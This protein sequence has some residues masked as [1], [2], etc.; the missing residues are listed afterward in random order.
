MHFIS[1]LT[2]ENI[3]KSVSTTTSTVIGTALLTAA[4]ALP[5]VEFAYGDA[6]PERG[7]VSFKYL[8]YQD[9][10]GIVTQSGSN[11]NGVNTVSGASSVAAS[12]SSSSG[13]QN[14]IGVVLDLHDPHPEHGRMD[15][16]SHRRSGAL[17]LC[18]RPCPSGGSNTG[19]RG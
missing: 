14:R 11:A 13:Y 9:S 2:P 17:G 3:M 18:S 6:V 8:N 19:S 5:S 16:L 10:Q 7:V 15:H 1:I 4:L 12:S